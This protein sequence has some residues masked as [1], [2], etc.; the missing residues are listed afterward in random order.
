MLGYILSTLPLCLG[1]IW[2]A[3]DG[4][5][6]GWHDMIAGTLVVKMHEPKVEFAQV[7][8]RVVSKD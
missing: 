6:R 8:T 5:K 2:I 4:K 3:F 7:G 1:F